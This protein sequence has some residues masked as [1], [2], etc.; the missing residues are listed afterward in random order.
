M[1]LD[2]SVRRVQRKQRARIEIVT[3]PD[4]AVEIRP[5]IA[6]A[7]VEKVQLRIVGTGQPGRAAAVLPAVLL[8]PRLGTGLAWRRHGPAAPQPFAGARIV[9]IDVAA[10]A[11]LRT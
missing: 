1:P 8:L 10:N 2:R 9:G 7:P 11:R 4:V 6:D 5:G 3:G